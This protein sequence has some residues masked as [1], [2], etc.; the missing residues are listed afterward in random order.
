[1]SENERFGRNFGQLAIEGS[2]NIVVCDGFGQ[3]NKTGG[4]KLF[5]KKIVVE[6]LVI[7]SLMPT[8]VTKL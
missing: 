8:V 5:V 6:I 1:M 2:S 7:F 4:M 3:V